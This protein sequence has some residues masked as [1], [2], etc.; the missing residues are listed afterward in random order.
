MRAWPGAWHILINGFFG[1]YPENAVAFF[2]YVLPLQL[3]LLEFY[4]VVLK[5]SNLVCNG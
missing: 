3:V 1:S 4:F 2:T 5:K